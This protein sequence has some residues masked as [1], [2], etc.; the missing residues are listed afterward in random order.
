MP[1]GTA[2]DIGRSGAPS[3]DGGD[4]IIDDLRQDSRPI[5]GIDARQTHFV[6]K[7][8]IAE[9]FLDDALTVVERALNREGVDVGPIG[10][11]HLP[12]LDV[13]HPPLRIE[14]E[15]FDL[16]LLAES[17]NRRS[18]GIARGRSNNRRPG[19]AASQNAIHRLAQ[20]LHGE[21]LEGQRRSMEQFEREQVVVELRKRRD[22][23]V[24][25]AG[26]GG[27]G[28]R[29]HFCVIEIL[30]D[31]GR[32]EPCSRFLIRNAP[33]RPDRVRRQIGNGERQIEAAVAREAGEKGVREAE[34]RRRAARRNVIHD[35]RILG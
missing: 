30:G 7:S 27:C 34:C 25:E 12:A 21:I 35:E 1:V 6:A 11:R 32:H 17:L 28:Q 20:P 2:K 31:E 33:Q 26:V 24:T 16:G 23:G 29:V 19:V 10:R 15:H 4:E 22:G 18:A 8:E 3:A 9:Q 13:R 14:D 5:D